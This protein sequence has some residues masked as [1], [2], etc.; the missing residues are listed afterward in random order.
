VKA[1]LALAAATTAVVLGSAPAA[2][3]YPTPPAIPT[4]ISLDPATIQAGTCTTLHGAGFGPATVDIT[5]DGNPVG[6]APVQNDGTVSQLLCMPSNTTP[7]DHTIQVVGSPAGGGSALRR[8]SSAA[9]TRTVIAQATLHVLAATSG[10]V[11]QPVTEPVT[12]PV[13]NPVTDPVTEPV[14]DP[15]TEPVTDPVTEPVNDP[16]SLPR[17][18]SGGSLSFT[19][20][21]VMSVLALGVGLVGAGA[22]T[23]RATRRRKA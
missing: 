21:P 17:T 16:V 6:S 7:G 18:D 3:A 8:R 11:T 13:T 2:L 20:F 22:M 15:V 19:G 9:A 10:T 1:A 12:E 4:T 23:L 14:T 5:N